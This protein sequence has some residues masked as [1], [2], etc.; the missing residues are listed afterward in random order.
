[1]QWL[2]DTSTRGLCCKSSRKPHRPFT[3]KRKPIASQTKQ[4]FGPLAFVMRD[5]STGELESNENG[6]VGWEEGG[7]S[8]LGS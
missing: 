1:M 5:K 4:L 2:W 6:A 8:F 3:I 7:K